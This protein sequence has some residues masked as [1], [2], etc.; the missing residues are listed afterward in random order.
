MSD[1]LGHDDEKQGQPK[2][3]MSRI[4]LAAGRSS[5]IIF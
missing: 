1:R 2:Q 5:L 3:P 4:I